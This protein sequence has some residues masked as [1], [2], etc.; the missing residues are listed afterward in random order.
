MLGVWNVDVSCMDKCSVRWILS[1]FCFLDL[2]VQQAVAFGRIRIT[3]CSRYDY[4]LKHF[5]FQ[6]HA[7]ERRRMRTHTVEWS[8]RQTFRRGAN[9]VL[10]T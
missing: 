6:H 8:T 5:Q 2:P 1:K 3:P 7:T 10:L 4:R 9:G